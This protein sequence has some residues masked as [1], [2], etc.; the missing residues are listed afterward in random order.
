[1]NKKALGLLFICIIGLSGCK[2]QKPAPK[3]GD[4]KQVNMPFSDSTKNAKVSFFDAD[5]NEFED[6]E[7]FVLDEESGNKDIM[8]AQNSS[9]ETELAWG[10]PA[11][12]QGQTQVVY[13]DYDSTQPRADQK[14]KLATVKNKVK[15]WTQQGYNV[16]CKGHACKWHGTRSYNVA[17]SNQRAKWMA[18]IC[19]ECQI[20][21]NSIKFF[22]VGNEEP[23]SNETTFE[24]QA[25]NRR[26]EI[27][28]V[29]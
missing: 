24:S 26:V 3:K 11:V 2:K 25:V 8:V 22:G 28:P 16:V 14:G 1:M 20:P 9:N 18:D 12:Q 17:L 19:K 29:A 6:N 21:A 27:Y 23:V 13:F 10:H 4:S 7:S 15:E 5:V